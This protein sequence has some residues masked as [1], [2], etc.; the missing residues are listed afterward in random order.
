MSTGSPTSPFRSQSNNSRQARRSC[1]VVGPP[2]PSAGPLAV[3]TQQLVAVVK[4]VPR[5]ADRCHRSTPS[6]LSFFKGYGSDERRS[7]DR[8]GSPRVPTT[9][10]SAPPGTYVRKISLPRRSEPIRAVRETQGQVLH[11][12]IGAS[13]T[14]DI[15]S[16]G[17]TS[18]Q[19]FTNS[20]KR[21][22]RPI[23]NRHRI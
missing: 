7:R 6:I 8:G 18:T 15:H 9:C 20:A 11:C 1:A 22:E 2:Q 23:W 5:N 13:L 21:D 3:S 16:V 14:P 17:S 12:G 10:R 4:H 19:C